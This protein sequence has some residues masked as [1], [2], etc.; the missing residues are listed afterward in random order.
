MVVVP[1]KR[2][3]GDINTDDSK[4]N[5][6]HMNKYEMTYGMTEHRQ[7]WKITMKKWRLSRIRGII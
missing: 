5:R 1:G 6:E 4:N 2:R 3:R 7:F